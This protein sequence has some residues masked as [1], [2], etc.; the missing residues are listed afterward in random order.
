MDWAV[1]GRKSKGR[2]TPQLE[3]LDHPLLDTSC[4]I[5]EVPFETR[6]ESEH[7]ANDDFIAHES[8]TAPSA[9]EMTPEVSEKAGASTR[10]GLRWTEGGSDGEQGPDQS[11]EGAAA[12]NKI[13]RLDVG[14]VMRAGRKVW[15]NTHT[16]FGWMWPD[17][18]RTSPHN[19]ATPSLRIPRYHKGFK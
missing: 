4:P 6:L 2:Q 14:N 17:P 9:T 8:D 16:A 13:W 7:N 15:G 19:A 3:T 10:M 18:V 11:H 12:T 5:H 1:P